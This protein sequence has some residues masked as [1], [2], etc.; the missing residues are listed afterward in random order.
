MGLYESVVRP[1]VFRLEPEFVHDAAMTCLRAGLIR[2]RE[3]LSPLLQQ[4]LFGVMFRN[5][6]GLA[7]GFDKNAAALNAWGDLGFGHVEIGTVTYRAQ[8]GN[9]KP[10][11]FR[12]PADLALINRMGFNNDGAETIASRLEDSGAIPIGVNLG[13]SRIAAIENAVED[14]AASYRL[15]H[16]YG[17]YAVVNVSSPNTPGLRRLQDRKPLTDI[18]QA[19]ME[20]DPSKPLLVKVAPDL[21]PHALDEVVDVALQTGCQGLIATNTTLE[22]TGLTHDP[23]EEGGLS[24]APLAA[25][26]D[27][28]LSHLAKASQG[29]LVL[30]GTG[31][32][33]TGD[34]LYRKISLGAHLGQIYTGWVY[35]G[36]STIPR[37][38]EQ[39]VGRMQREG[40]MNLAELRGSALT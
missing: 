32:I 20:I 22:R 33:F 36:P 31:G 8:P 25:R 14:Y 38:L 15:L 24:G 16:R 23:N 6:I 10:R 40:I 1:L 35:G 28:V 37:M 13:K 12:L 21:E 4:E 30:I 39:L 34:D 2:T 5:P 17:A 26:S 9:P 11:L 18:I 19:L 7:A 3:V 29:K 27:A